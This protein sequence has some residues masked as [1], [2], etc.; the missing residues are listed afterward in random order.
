MKYNL[1]NKLIEAVNRGI[2]FALDDFDDQDEIQGQSNS[3]VNHDRGT[4]E[5][6]ILQK[7]LVDLGLPSGT[8]WCKYNIGVDTDHLYW[9][10]NWRGCDFA[11]G[12][13]D[14]KNVYDWSTYKWGK[15]DAK[16]KKAN[17]WE[18]WEMKLPIMT[19]YC[20]Y[21]HYGIVDHKTKLDLI[22]D[23]AYV[24][25]LNKQYFEQHMPTIEQI[26]ELEKYTT[27]KVVKNYQNIRSLNGCLFTSKI[28]N[29]ELFFP[30]TGYRS[31]SKKI[32]CEKEF[33]FIVSNECPYSAHSRY[34]LLLSGCY[35]PGDD[36]IDIE[37]KTTD[38]RWGRPIRG[39][40]DNIK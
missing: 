12:E 13:T 39:V 14:I 23:A 2:K 40:V 16:F 10:K 29:E 38:K 6:L 1:N 26:R 32:N 31:R 11:W 18:Q 19:K 30:F 20:D 36:K 25:N 15:N 28:N 17:N 7:E 37:I 34:N 22:D 24:N 27:Q 9:Y 3:K 35:F 4:K 21:E 5:W 33:F 8:L